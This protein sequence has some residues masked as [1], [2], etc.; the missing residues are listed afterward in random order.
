MHVFDRWGNLMFSRE[1][2]FPDNN[3]L[4]DGWDGKFNGQYVNPGVFVYIIEVQFLDGKV[5]LYRGD[6][7]VVR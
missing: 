1:G 7:T 3:N 2:F 6:V 4:A 5:L